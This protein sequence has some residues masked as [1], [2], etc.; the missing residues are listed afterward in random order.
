MREKFRAFNPLQIIANIFMLIG[1]IGSL[2][3]KDNTQDFMI[4]LYWFGL[5]VNVLGLTWFFATWTRG[6]LDIDVKNSKRIFSELDNITLSFVV[7]YV[8]A[9]LI[10]LFILNIKPEFRNN[11]YLIIGSYIFTIIVELVTYIAEEKAYKETAKL[12]DKNKLGKND[13]N[14]RK[15]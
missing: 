7:L 14:D 10:I 15:K 4:G 2:V 12:I 1:V 3:L 11:L 13:R 8:L 6:G 9:F 5:V